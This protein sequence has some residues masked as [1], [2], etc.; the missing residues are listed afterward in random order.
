MTKARVHESMFPQNTSLTNALPQ[1][2][3]LPHPSGPLSVSM[4]CSGCS[5]QKTVLMV[6]LGNVYHQVQA[7]KGRTIHI[8]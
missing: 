5:Q 6:R 4:E 8:P 1:F 2:I 7:H 3:P